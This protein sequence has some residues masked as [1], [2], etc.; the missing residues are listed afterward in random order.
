MNT[1]K[2]GD[3]VTVLDPK[4]VDIELDELDHMWVDQMDNTIGKNFIVGECIKKPDDSYYYCLTNGWTYHQDFLALYSDKKF[5]V[6]DEVQIIRKA[7]KAESTRYIWIDAMTD[8]IDLISEVIDVVPN[9][10]KLKI[11]NCW[12]HNNTLAL[13]DPNDKLTTF[14]NSDPIKIDDKD[15]EISFPCK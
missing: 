4:I 1:F 5:S 3:K 11:D 12:Y 8:K 6:G 13:L 14:V 2:K 15:I 10:S 7:T 9:Y